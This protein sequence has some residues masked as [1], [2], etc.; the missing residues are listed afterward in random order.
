MDHIVQTNK[1]FKGIAWSTTYIE[2]NVLGTAAM[3]FIECVYSKRRVAS[4]VPLVG[5]PS[6]KS[7]SPIASARDLAI[8]EKLERLDR[9]GR[10]L[11]S[12]RVREHAGAHCMV[13]VPMATVARTEAAMVE[14]TR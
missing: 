10:G 4:S 2:D 6:N 3:V 8:C 7:R 13:K 11:R 14:A 12:P 1:R 9:V 5:I